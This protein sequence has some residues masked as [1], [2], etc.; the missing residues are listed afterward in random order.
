ME[1]LQNLVRRG[2]R[3]GQGRMGS[4]HIASRLPFLQAQFNLRRGDPGVA[5]NFVDF[6][7]SRYGL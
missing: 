4:R 1:W 7:K 5:S 2:T 3:L 6:F